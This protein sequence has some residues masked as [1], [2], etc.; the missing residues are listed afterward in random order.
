MQTL[1]DP[2]AMLLG[3][4]LRLLQAAAWRHGEHHL[5]GR[6]L[7]AQGVAP[8]LPMTANPHQID[9]RLM[10]DLDGLRL[11][12]PAIEKG[13]KR[14]EHMSRSK[15]SYSIAFVAQQTALERI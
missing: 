8:R 10:Y 3:E 14:H 4:S 5:A 1:G 9:R 15:P 7:D 11:S 13:A 12:R 2:P 6:D